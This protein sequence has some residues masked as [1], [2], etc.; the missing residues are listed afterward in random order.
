MSD[1][2]KG[3]GTPAD[4]PKACP[5]CETVHRVFHEKPPWERWSE[6]PPTPGERKLLAAI[7]GSDPPAPE[8][9]RLNRIKASFARDIIARYRTAAPGKEPLGEPT[10]ETHLLSAYELEDRLHAAEER[11]E[12]LQGLLTTE[13]EL[14]TTLTR[15]NA[16]LR[17]RVENLME[18]LRYAVAQVPDL[19]T[20]PGIVEA[21]APAEGAVK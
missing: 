16:A 14:T 11:A 6:P 19:G 20:V 3:V 18:A 21:L 8:E 9:T 10:R 15:E 7:F 4:V 1:K 2:E 13:A 5:A 12:G 17:E